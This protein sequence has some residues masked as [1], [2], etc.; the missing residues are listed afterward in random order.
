MYFRA[1]VEFY[2][3]FDLRGVYSLLAFITWFFS[4]LFVFGI[5]IYFVGSFSG[6]SNEFS[7]TVDVG[8]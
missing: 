2:G 3:Y 8:R 4:Y 1:F 6:L 5:R 7:Y